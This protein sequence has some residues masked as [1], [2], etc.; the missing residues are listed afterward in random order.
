MRSIG[1]WKLQTGQLNLGGL[2]SNGTRYSRVPKTSQGNEWV[3]YMRVYMVLDQGT[4]AK[5]NSQGLSGYH[6]FTGQGSQ[7]RCDNKRFFQRHLIL[8]HTIGCLQKS[9][10]PERI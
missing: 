1:S 7:D 9:W 8:F 2:K 10:Q 5:S 3:G 6:G 4:H